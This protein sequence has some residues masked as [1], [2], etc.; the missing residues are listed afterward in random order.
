VATGLVAALMRAACVEKHRQI[1]TLVTDIPGG[2]RPAVA[3]GKRDQVV[4]LGE[5][6]A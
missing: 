2:R 1:V 6:R 3:L 5:L 4:G